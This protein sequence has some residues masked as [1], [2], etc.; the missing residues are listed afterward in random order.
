MSIF[1]ICLYLIVGYLVGAAASDYI[2]MDM[3]LTNWSSMW[4]YAWIGLWALMLF[5]TFTFW[6]IIAGILIMAFFFAKEKFF[7]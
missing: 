7:D 1:K 6:A 5:V 3:G 2:Y 4:T